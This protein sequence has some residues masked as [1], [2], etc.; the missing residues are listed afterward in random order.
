[1]PEEDS[2]GVETNVR[3]EA[4]GE[5]A[6]KVG[7]VAV[8]EQEERDSGSVGEDPMKGDGEKV[9]WREAEVKKG[10]GDD[11]KPEPAEALEAV[12]AVGEGMV[13]DGEEDS[14]ED[15][16]D[17]GVSGGEGGEAGGS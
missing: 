8:E 4:V 10:N 13:K 9:L 16:V 17:A 11:R 6:S 5:I 15:S 12:E 1:M 2:V 3:D 7:T 14:V